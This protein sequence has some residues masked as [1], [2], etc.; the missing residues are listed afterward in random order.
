MISTTPTNAEVDAAI[1]VLSVLEM[2]KDATKLKAALSGIKDAQDAAVAERKAADK[3]ISQLKA[4]ANA[5][6]AQEAQIEQQRAKVKEESAKAF[7][8]A[9]HIEAE[10]AAMVEE[11]NRFDHW[12]AQQREDLAAAQAKV[13]SDRVANA[14]RAEDLQLIEASCAAKA[15]EAEVA[16]RT[17][18]AR[19]VEYEAKIAN[20]KAMV[21]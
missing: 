5:L 11:R 14:R 21:G 15:A 3:S 10:R 20:L 1:S 7:K 13:E 9:E 19:C 16:I 18:N 12:M 17:A 2:A 4:D 6:L 8:A